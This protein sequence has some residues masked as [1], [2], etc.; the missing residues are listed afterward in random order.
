MPGDWLLTVVL[1]LPLAGVPLAGLLSGSRQSADWLVLGILE[2]ETVLCLMLLAAVAGG[3]SIVLPLAATTVLGAT[4]EWRLAVDTLSAAFILLVV[5]VDLLETSF[6]A[7]K[8]VRMDEAVYQRP[9]ALLSLAMAIGVLASGSLLT[10]FAFWQL[11]ILAASLLLILPQRSSALRAAGWFLATNEVGA[12]C[13]FVAVAL[14]QSQNTGQT[15]VDWLH[16]G[17]PGFQLPLL[18]LLAVAS[19]AMLAA[20]PL[21]SWLGQAVGSLSPS[22]A[23]AWLGLQNKLGLYLLLRLASDAVPSAQPLWSGLLISLGALSILVA[24]ASVLRERSVWR[25]VGGLFLLQTGLMLLGLGSGSALGVAGAFFLAFSQ[26]AAGLSVLLALAAVRESVGTAEPSLAGGLARRLPLPALV[27]LVGALGMAGLP[28]FPGYAGLMLVYQGLAAS[29]EAWRL[30]FLAVGLLGT[31]VTAAL[32]L[33]LGGLL[34]LGERHL[35][36]PF[37][38]PLSIFPKIT[39]GAVLLV[40]LAVGLLPRL[41]LDPIVAPVTGVAPVGSWADLALAPARGGTAV[42]F[43]S[44]LWALALLVLPL[45]AVLLL[46]RFERTNPYPSEPAELPEVLKLAQSLAPGRPLELASD[47]P[48]ARSERWWLALQR[49]LAGDS[50]DPYRLAA[51]SLSATARLAARVAQFTFRFLLR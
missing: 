30:S 20:A 24:A 13:L 17:D 43:L 7:A 11:A 22:L 4:F 23:P 28:P 8:E 18:L 3:Q 25:T 41:L 14:T 6:F 40:C 2:I 44:P 12:T 15:L 45:L 39:L 32:L 47:Q 26:T 29:G 46:A 38:E 9:L 48:Q 19:A 10:L 33:R 5:V 21:H 49:P 42:G 51:A 37:A 50:A 35:Q 27:F 36:Q 31:V 16:K 1:L 34:F